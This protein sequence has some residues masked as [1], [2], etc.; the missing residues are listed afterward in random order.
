M[1]TLSFSTLRI[2]SLG[3]M[4]GLLGTIQSSWA[5]ASVEFNRQ[6]EHYLDVLSKGKTVARYMH[7]HD[8]S[9]RE[10]LHATYKPYLHIFDP[11][12]GK[13]I[14]KGP[15]GQFSHHRGL[16]LGWNRLITE[17]GRFDFWHMSGSTQVHRFFSAIKIQKDH[18][19]VTSNI[20]WVDPNGKCVIKE[21]R[22]MTFIHDTIPDAIGIIDLETELM[23]TLD[24][25]LE[26]D[27]EHAGIQ[28][29]PADQINRKT[30]EY[31]FPAEGQNPRKDLNMPWVAQYHEIGSRQYSVVLLNATNN[32]RPTRFSAYRDYG[33]FGSFFTQ[34]LIKESTLRLHYRWIILRGKTPPRETIQAWFDRW[35]P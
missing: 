4:A 9:T 31:L 14:T 12:T 2:L 30:N 8:P 21:L 24:L 20:D 19:S 6:N 15:G 7:A 1:Q 16:F 22:T 29:R 11:E 27:P 32:P 3:F 34:D 5:A 35:N 23:P 25:K 18:S 10:S 33:R 28:Y 13:P 17:D 26:G